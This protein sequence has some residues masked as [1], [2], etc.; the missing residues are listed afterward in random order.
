MC[1]ARM[2]CRM[3]LLQAARLDFSLADASTGNNNPARI[4]IIAITTSNSINVKAI[5]F[6]FFI[7]GF[8][9]GYRLSLKKIGLRI[10]GGN[11]ISCYCE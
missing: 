8:E 4:A 1:I 9:G 5:S 11:Q 6:F 3:L 7:R 10:G 2:A